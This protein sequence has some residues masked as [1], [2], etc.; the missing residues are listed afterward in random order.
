MS[1]PLREL[2]PIPQQSSKSVIFNVW[3]P[4]QQHQHHLQILGPR[5]DLLNQKLWGR[6]S[7]ICVLT[8]RPLTSHMIQM[9]AGVW[10]S[11]SN[12]ESTRVET[13]QS[14]SDCCWPISHPAQKENNHW[15]WPLCVNHFIVITYELEQDA[16]Q[17]KSH[18]PAWC[19]RKGSTDQTRCQVHQNVY[20]GV[21]LSWC[22]GLPP[23]ARA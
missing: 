12:P 8:S 4:G 6:G 9:C 14:F 11:L 3:S 7:A 2:H 22:E 18:V 20:T 5:P 21:M 23:W 15:E 16:R 10:E 13:L 17:Y 1:L 19:A